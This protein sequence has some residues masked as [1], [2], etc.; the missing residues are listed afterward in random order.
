M[1]LSEFF[2]S[3]HGAVASAGAD[4][5]GAYTGSYTAP[6]SGSPT[7]VRVLLTRGVQIVGDYGE[8]STKQDVADLDLTQITP[9][10]GATLVVDGT[11]YKLDAEQ[12]NDGV[13]AAWSLRRG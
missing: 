9:A 12:S 10:H 11:T 4:F 3:A 1:N 8:T 5:F 7:A 2:E 13:R 6:G